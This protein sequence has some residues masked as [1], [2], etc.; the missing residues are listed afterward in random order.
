MTMLIFQKVEMDDPYWTDP[1]LLAKVYIRA[2]EIVALGWGQTELHQRING[3]DHSC[4]T[5]AVQQAAQDILGRN[6]RPDEWSPVD[7]MISKTYA[8]D[9]PLWWWNDRPER[10]QAEVEAFL[11]AVAASLERTA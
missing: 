8:T 4:A 1:H 9:L 3:I 5:G 2:A 7:A 11:R 10:T 6:L